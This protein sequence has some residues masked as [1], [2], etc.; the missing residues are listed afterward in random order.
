MT[1]SRNVV[2]RKPWRMRCWLIPAVAGLLAG[3]TPDAFGPSNDPILGG[4]PY[5]PTTA[6]PVAANNAPRREGSIP[7]IPGAPSAGGNAI[8]AGGSSGPSMDPSRNLQLGSGPAP[9]TLT[10]N[11]GSIGA[12]TWSPPSGG[13]ASTG[14]VTIG[15]PQPTGNEKETVIPGD[16]R[17]IPA[18]PGASGGVSAGPTLESLLTQLVSRGVIYEQLQW[19][20]EK[21]DWQF[22]CAVP[23]RQ[24]PNDSRVVETRG[25]DPAS[26]IKAALEKIDTSR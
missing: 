24:N 14:G 21:S 1:Q 5:R 6:N 4:A 23:S 18:V 13:P 22:K 16:T 12:G 15:G 17:P 25:P 26:A 7:P 10:G 3:C 8:L 9:G 19:S 20:G 11:T 2:G